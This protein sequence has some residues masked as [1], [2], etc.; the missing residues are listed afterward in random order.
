DVRPALEAECGGVGEARAFFS[1]FE[2]FAETPDLDRL[3]NIL[4]DQLVPTDTDAFGWL[5]FRHAVRQW[6]IFKNWPEPNGRILRGHVVQ[7]ITKRRPQPIRQDFVVPDS[8]GPPSEAF[9][10]SIRERIGK[11]DNPITILWGTPGRGKSTYLSF[12]TQALQ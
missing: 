3:E 4:R 6:A 12:L 5:A 2:F 10:R 1:V 8:Y 7:L 11:D 9:D